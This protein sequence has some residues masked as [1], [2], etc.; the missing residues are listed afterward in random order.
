LDQGDRLLL[1]IK[2]YALANLS[3]VLFDVG[4]QPVVS[5]QTSEVGAFLNLTYLASAR[6]DYAIHVLENLTDPSNRAVSCELEIMLVVFPV[7]PVRPYVLYGIALVGFGLVA[8]VY[9]KRAGVKTKYRGEWYEPRSYLLPALFLGSTIGFALI[10]SMYVLVGSSLSGT[11]SDAL[12]V[13]FSALNICSLLIGIVALH[14]KP[15][16]V[17]LETLLISIAVWFGTLGLLVILLPSILVQSAP[18]WD[19]G[20]FLRTMGGLTALNSAF[21]QVTAIAVIMVIAYCLSFR[22][23][24]HRVYSY[25]VD[26]EIVEAGTLKEL[27]R[28][29]EGS[30][31]RKNLEEFFQELREKDLEA[32]AFLF[33]LMSEHTKTGTNSFSYHSVIAHRRDVFSKDIYERDPAQKILQP[34]GLLRVSGKGRF[35]RYKLL[36]GN[37]IVNRLI[38]IFKGISEKG[39]LESLAEWS[40]VEMLRQRRMRYAGELREKSVP[41]EENE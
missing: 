26:T 19:P 39:G 32:S 30:I 23:G 37:P 14:E 2:P 3:L 36:V 13:A 31:G 29:L 25:Q 11:L 15:L 4:A 40:G 8:L 10:F 34:L 17:F 16:I 9:S 7:D 1:G 12:L 21:Y 38:V 41:L 18:Y 20:V 5:L 33:F 35:K 22:Y 6:G 28:K 27:L 24:K